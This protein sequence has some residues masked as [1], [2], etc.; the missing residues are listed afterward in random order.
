ME[1]ACEPRKCPVTLGRRTVTRGAWSNV[2]FRNSFLV[3]CLPHCHELL[4]RSAQRF[5][6]K[7]IEMRGKGLLHGRAQN[8]RH[9]GHEEARP[10][11]L[12]EGTQLILE[13]LGLLPGKSRH[14]DRSTI[15]L[16]RQTMTGLAVLYFSLKL[17][18][19]HGWC[20]FR[21]NRCGKSNDEKCNM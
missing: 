13:V 21:A 2:G 8:S 18:F 6:I 12:D 15:T 9:P 5:G 1:L 3:D 17:A 19:G 7:Y 14:R 10:L 16:S 20:I 4:W 11:A